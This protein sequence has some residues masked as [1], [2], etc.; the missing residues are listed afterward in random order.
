LGTIVDNSQTA[1]E[2]ITLAKL[3]YNVKMV[4]LFQGETLS[5]I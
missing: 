4:D 3:D 1:K 2:A 5:G